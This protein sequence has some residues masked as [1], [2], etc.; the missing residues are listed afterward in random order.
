MLPSYRDAQES[1]AKQPPVAPMTVTRQTQ[2][3]RAAV[4][5]TA[6]PE[7]PSVVLSISQ[8]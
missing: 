2:Q 6:T 1:P 8:A 4:K 5:T 7:D 3:N